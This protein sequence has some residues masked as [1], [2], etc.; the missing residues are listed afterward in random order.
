MRRNFTI[1]KNKRAVLVYS[2]VIFLLQTI[3]PAFHGVMA[4]AVDGYTDTLCTLYGPVTVF[5]PLADESQQS[6]NE[7]FEC[8]VCILQ[9]NLNG[10]AVVHALWQIPNY[11]DDGSAQAGPLYHVSIL[12]LYAPFLSRA[13]PA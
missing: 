13:P 9:A 3:A 4:K 10:E 6:Q 7:C 11:F 2:A 1:T 12:P 5:V 8:P